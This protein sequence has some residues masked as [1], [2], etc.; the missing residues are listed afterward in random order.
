MAVGN[1][2]PSGFSYA[3]AA[4]GTSA[5]A[6]QAP[7]SKVTSGAATPANSVSL[8]ASSGGNWADDVEENEVSKAVE[9]PNVES[10][11]GEV[12]QLKDSAI[13]RTKM[14]EKL[15]NGTPESA[16]PLHT[17]SSTAST[18]TRD[19][20][21]SAPTGSSSDITWESKSQ[22]SEPAWIVER[23]ER[24]NGS[25]GSDD[26]A[27]PERK[28]KKNAS[29]PKEE[30]K[31][32]VLQEALP[33][34]VNP[35]QKRAED[36][37]AK[38]VPIPKPTT[39]SPDSA[40][41]QKE[42]QQPP[43]PV[44]RKP[45]PASISQRQDSSHTAESPPKTNATST[46]RTDEVRITNRQSSK[47]SAASSRTETGATKSGTPQSRSLPNLTST[48]PPVKDETSWPTPDTVQDKERKDAPEKESEE[49]RD[50]DNTPSAK[51][52]KSEWKPMA[53]TPNVIWETSSMN[54]P[55]E[56]KPRPA[57]SERGGRGGTRGRGS[58][59]GGAAAVNGG[60]RRTVRS[61]PPPAKSEADHASR[62]ST[63]TTERDEIT[64]S[65]KQSAS[66]APAS[67]GP[68]SESAAPLSQAKVTNDA[69]TQVDDMNVRSE[70]RRARS[71][72]KSA[73]AQSAEGDE[74]PTPAPI[75]R[76]KSFTT[77]AADSGDRTRADPPVRLV[78]TENR[79]ESRNG[80][81]FRDPTW[82]GP[83]R[84]SGGKR[85]GRGRGG[86][87][88]NAREPPHGHPYGN[89]FQNDFNGHP[90][91]GVP[92]SP[93]AYGRGNHHHFSYPPGHAR[94]GWSRGGARSNS[95]PIETY[96]SRF[97]PQ[98][99]G[100]NSSHMSS[101]NGYVPGMSE[102]SPMQPLSAIMP[103]PQEAQ[104]QLL[105]IVTVQLEYYFGVENLIRDIFLRKHMDSQ[106]FVFLDF[107]AGF[108]RLKSLTSDKDLL[109]LACLNSEA[110]EIRVGD[111]GKE[112]LRKREGWQQFVRPIEERDSS[113]QTDGPQ[114][115]Q[116]PE[117]PQLSMPNGA[118]HFQGP[119]SAGP[120]AMHQ[121]MNHRSYDSGMMNGFA[122][123]FVPNGDF[124]GS[125][126]SDS[127][128][129]E[130]R[131][132]RSAKSPIYENGVGPTDPSFSS[133]E[134][135][136]N[137]E[138]DVFPD[139]Q[140][141]ALGIVV[142]LSEQQ[143]PY[144]TAAS[145]TFSNGSIDSRSIAS[146][147]DKAADSETHQLPNGSPQV[148]GIEKRPSLS[149]HLSPNKARSPEQGPPNVEKEV[150]WA[151]DVNNIPAGTTY[152]PYTQLREKALEQRN[153]AATGN[154][155]YDLDVLYQF[156]CHFL[157]RNFNKRMYDEFKH[158]AHEDAHERHS[159]TGTNN[160]LKFYAHSLNSFDAIRDRIAKDY[161][162]L[163]KNEPQ[164]LE[165]AAFKQ[166]RSA[167]RNGALNLKNRK[168]LSDN[169]DAQM[170]EALEA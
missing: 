77:P 62:N 35:W 106:G 45:K 52:K 97:V 21:P 120:Q 150:C 48:L 119:Y 71:P 108:N 151:K 124:N 88:V 149:R 94:G 11:D 117:R 51:R 107:I 10:H 83:G 41:V 114:Q 24:Q 103:S 28:G 14:E 13:T 99:F 167:W 47:P 26:T 25:H 43:A 69:S 116:R 37:K 100:G 53:V 131:R 2:S 96:Y 144:H 63:N 66:T 112:R 95:I 58:V 140:M 15:S 1:F 70:A 27:K 102:F 136:A 105:M 64:S 141:S 118:L 17:G 76:K 75:P 5:P 157:C 153:H 146:E 92:P 134:D 65:T 145:R 16:S 80:D 122:P 20:S 154:C 110:I 90:S 61:S 4:R 12:A 32:V 165:G 170:K 139:E 164:A 22:A 132:G 138:P 67:R 89:G 81:V 55:R 42:N 113:A 36:A 101:P 115:L 133:T 98:P 23:K 93:S 29:T 168:K 91:Y 18:T 7:S 6:S 130:E 79:K 125:A 33:P 38:T 31:A 39:A 156:W 68:V 159:L 56:R 169:M 109:K 82:T 78:A 161:I 49:K 85:G 9:T 158:F 142:K 74:I 147:L 127:F 57:G 166:L 143:A 129:G 3:Q 152:E 30:P 137:L 162:E 59:R 121:R 155:P 123:Q 86:N 73:A 46:K 8:E 87:G 72:K 128:N 44:Q 104:E 160:L 163:V 40:P 126:Y 111:D 60:D 84:G 19:D 50:D 135:E 148:N 34:T 54:E